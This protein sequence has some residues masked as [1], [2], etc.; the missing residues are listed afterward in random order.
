MEQALYR[1]EDLM[2]ELGVKVKMRANKYNGT[3]PVHGGRSNNFNFYPD[4]YKSPG[5]WHCLSEHCEGV[6]KGNIIGLVR[7]V[8]SHQ[9]M[10]W[11][12]AGED[13]VSW[14]YAI[15]W[16]CNWLGVEFDSLE[17]D[18]D[19]FNRHKFTSGI[20]VFAKKVETPKGICSRE[21]L[22][23]HLIIPAQYFIERDYSPALLD[24]YDVG[25]CGNLKSKLYGRVVVPIYDNDHQ[26]VIGCI[27]RSLH[28]ECPLCK[29]HHADGACPGR[30]EYANYC[31]WKVPEGFNDKNHL[32]NM[33]KAKDA[34][35]KTRCVVLVEGVGDVWR[36]VSAGIDNVVGLFGSDLQEP[37]IISLEC[38]GATTVICLTDNDTAGD[39]VI[40][41]IKEKC[42]FA[43]NIHRPKF[44]GHDIGGLTEEY[45]VSS[46]LKD[47]IESK[48][49]K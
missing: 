37:Q 11:T 17:P 23:K 30:W 16:L 39:N 29:M 18:L 25:Y 4:G 27:G 3:C 5:F 21:K 7:G 22:R 31:K 9:E 35:Y 26:Y 44:E 34:I 28:P 20:E 45:I 10:G 2:D 33:W 47:F 8:L 48:A 46:G 6:F 38:S 43:V 1:I 24:E 36:L 49:R 32:Y 42:W 40:R 14:Q 41:Q 12:K 19:K 13:T 15:D